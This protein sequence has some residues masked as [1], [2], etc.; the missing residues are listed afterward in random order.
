M[1]VFRGELDDCLE[2]GKRVRLSEMLQLRCRG[3]VKWK[4]ALVAEQTYGKDMSLKFTSL[5]IVKV[6]GARE[7]IHKSCRV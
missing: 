4:C 5:D 1:T 7:V 3:T 2:Y 6:M